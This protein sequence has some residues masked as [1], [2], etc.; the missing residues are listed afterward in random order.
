MVRFERMSGL[1]WLLSSCLLALSAAPLQAQVGPSRAHPIVGASK[2]LPTM[3]LD[4]KN[5]K[6]VLEVDVNADGQVTG[7]R[8]AERSDNGIYDERMRGY[9]KSTPFMPALNVEGQPVADTL[10]IT[11]IYTVTD[12]RDHTPTNLRNVSQIDGDQPANIAARLGRMRCA[13]LLWEF[14]FMKRRAPKAT[15]DHEEIFTIAFGMYLA[16]GNISQSAR[17]ALIADWSNLVRRVLSECRAKPD[18]AYWD[19]VFIP[20]FARAV[21]HVSAPVP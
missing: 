2:A 12:H 17:D 20:V 5:R 3:F 10:R 4:Q 11:H 18:A 19:G 7:T 13:D 15:L 21:P 16:A 14:D 6:V 8:V 9:W 1:T